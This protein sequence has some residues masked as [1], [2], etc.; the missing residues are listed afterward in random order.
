VAQNQ[1]RAAFQAE[2]ARAQ[3]TRITGFAQQELDH[4]LALQKRHGTY[5]C[6]VCGYYALTPTPT[7]HCKKCRHPMGAAPGLTPEA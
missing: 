7:Q 1:P 3:L 6:L 5:C 2:F 4:A